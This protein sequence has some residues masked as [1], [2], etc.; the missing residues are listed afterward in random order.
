MAGLQFAF[1]RYM[2]RTLRHYPRLWALHES[3]FDRPRIRRY[4]ASDRRLPFD[5]N[6]IFRHYPQLDAAAT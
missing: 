5:N 2:A 4:V 1:P 3:V 6:G